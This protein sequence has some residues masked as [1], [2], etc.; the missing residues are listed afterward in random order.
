MISLPTALVPFMYLAWIS[1]IALLV[2]ITYVL[3]ARFKNA[4][5]PSRLVMIF[6]LL[7]AY[8]FLIVVTIFWSR[9]VRINLPLLLRI[10]EW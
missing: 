8:A 1:S 2:L 7:I 9:A 10:R 3:L 4:N 5:W 6:I